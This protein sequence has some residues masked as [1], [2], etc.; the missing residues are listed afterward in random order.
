MYLMKDMEG[1]K[2][3]IGLQIDILKMLEPDFR[4]ILEK[5]GYKDLM[6]WS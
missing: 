4:P 6:W 3:E 1:L 5:V 2:K